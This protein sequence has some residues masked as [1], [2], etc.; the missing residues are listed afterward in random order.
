[1]DR[2]YD[3][4]LGSHP[5]VQSRIPHYAC[6]MTCMTFAFHSCNWQGSLDE[7]QFKGLLPQQC[8]SQEPN[9]SW[10]VGILYRECSGLI[11]KSLKMYILCVQAILDF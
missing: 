7:I 3:F 11:L 2:K 4:G 5:L 8:I 1:M 6:H 9:S 10:D